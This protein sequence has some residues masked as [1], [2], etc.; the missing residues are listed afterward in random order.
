MA[1]KSAWIIYTS[2]TN[3]GFDK[4][5]LHYWQIYNIC[6]WRAL[7]Y[8]C[9]SRKKRGDGNSYRTAPTSITYTLSHPLTGKFFDFTGHSCRFVPLWGLKDN[10]IT[11]CH[12][13]SRPHTVVISVWT[14]LRG[15]EGPLNPPCLLCLTLC[16][17]FRST[18]SKPKAQMTFVYWTP[19]I[20]DHIGPL[21]PK[22][23]HTSVSRFAIEMT[24][25]E[26]YL[27]WVT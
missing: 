2:Y 3:T 16:L 10:Y 18:T 21:T 12:P 6:S 11:H 19:I 13:S 23:T 4:C 7:R 25:Y 26:N 5:G 27:K 20:S 15:F 17:Q 14:W 1:F 9:S 22:H 8:V 24:Q